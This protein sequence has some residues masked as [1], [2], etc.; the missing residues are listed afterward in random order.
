MAANLVAVPFK[1]RPGDNDNF[2]RKE[3]NHLIIEVKNEGTTTATSVKVRVAFRG[4]GTSQNPRDRNP[5]EEIVVEITAGN[6]ELFEF[7]C[8][9][10]ACYD[11]RC[12]FDIT[13]DPGGGPGDRKEKYYRGV[14]QKGPDLVPVQ[15]D[16]LIGT[17]FY[18]KTNASGK[19]IFVNVQNQGTAEAV[20][21]TIRVDFKDNPPSKRA[22]TGPI[23]PHKT[24]PV[25]VDIPT[26]LWG[27]NFQA[28]VTVDVDNIVQESNK[29]NN[30]HTGF[31]KKI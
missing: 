24:K 9:S 11:P 14:C 15:E 29:K 21:S 3:N 31:C 30:E 4:Y 2:C 25:E 16:T 26:A 17:G 28:K 18:W 23:K 13:I 5:Q 10:D 7:D 20:D 19:K 6:S 12:V 8:P 1:K 22:A 27:T